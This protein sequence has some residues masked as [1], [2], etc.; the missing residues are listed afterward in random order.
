MFVGAMGAPGGGS[1]VVTARFLRH[2]Q[3]ICTDAFEDYTLT[4]IFTTILDW[5]M[6]KGY[7][8]PV[9]RLGKV[10]LECDATN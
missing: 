5:H 8:E 6:S 7:P 1:N 4:K 10:E 2:M 3:I 9:S